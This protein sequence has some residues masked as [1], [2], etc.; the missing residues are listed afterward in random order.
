MRTRRVPEDDP[1]QREAKAKAVQLELR[2]KLAE[3]EERYTCHIDLK[4]LALVRIN[5]P[6]LAVQCHVLRRSA[7]RIHTIYWNALNKDLEPLCCCRC[8]ASTF[9]VAFSDDQVAAFC[10]SCRG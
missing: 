10:A 8:G 3:L 1:A 5:C 6:A 9:S 2:R 4:P 7:A